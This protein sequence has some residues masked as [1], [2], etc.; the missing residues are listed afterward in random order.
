MSEKQHVMKEGKM[1][2]ERKEGEKELGENEGD[3]GWQGGRERE[4]EE[5]M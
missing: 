3:G 5:E 2:G 1:K 4:W